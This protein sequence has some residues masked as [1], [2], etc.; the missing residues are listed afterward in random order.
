MHEAGPGS[1][2]VNWPVRWFRPTCIR[3]QN[4]FLKIHCTGRKNG[5]ARAAEANQLEPP[6]Q[7]KNTFFRRAVEISKQL[8]FGLSFFFRNC[9]VTTLIRTEIF[10]FRI[11]S[12]L[13]FDLRIS[14][15]I[16][17]SSRSPTPSKL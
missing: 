5:R 2:L 4:P 9:D 7:I 14:E 13:S 6:G 17:T 12:E 16:L 1:S 15:R 8:N 10:L 11:P 3:C